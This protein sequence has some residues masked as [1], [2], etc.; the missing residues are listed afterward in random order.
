MLVLTRKAGEKVVLN[1]NIVVTVVEVQGNRVKLAFSAPDDVLILRGELASLKDGVER[2]QKRP[3][4]PQE[5][6]A[7]G[8]P[9]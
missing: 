1:G 8:A 5:D 4:W 3:E 9:R 2:V 7:V 6:V